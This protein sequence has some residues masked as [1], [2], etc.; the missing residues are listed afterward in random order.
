LKKLLKFVLVAGIAAGV[1]KMVMKKKEW[2]GL[3]ETQVRE[4]LDAGL[5]RRVDDA[6]KRQE[7]ADKVVGAMKDKGVIKDEPAS[8]MADVA[9]TAADVATEAVEAADDAKEAG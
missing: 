8:E 1:A 9:A 7:I 3:T 2:S 4:K 5:S 6:E